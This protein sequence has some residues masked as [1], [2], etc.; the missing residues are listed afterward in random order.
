[1]TAGSS[2]RPATECA[3]KDRDCSNRVRTEEQRVQAQQVPQLNKFASNK[4]GS[5]DP[6]CAVRALCPTCSTWYTRELDACS[7]ALG[8]VPHLCALGLCNTTTEG[9][10]ARAAGGACVLWQGPAGPREV[11]HLL[12]LSLSL[13]KLSQRCS[14]SATHRRT[15]IEEVE[16]TCL[17]NAGYCISAYNTQDAII[18]MGIIEYDTGFANV[19]MEFSA[20][21]FR[22]VRRRQL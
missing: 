1:M 12:W 2:E 3:L 13:I 10:Q 4:F 6:L 22:C 5:E 21:C 16:G 11:H 20:V 9:P 15:L 14:P 17:G 7:C 18:N 19:S 8:S